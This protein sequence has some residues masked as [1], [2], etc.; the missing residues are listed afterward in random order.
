MPRGD[1]SLVA[2]PFAWTRAGANVLFVESPA[3]VG[4]SYSNTSADMRV[5]DAHTAKDMRTFLVRFL[6][7]YPALASADMYIS[8]E[9][10][11]GHYV[12][13][14]A[15]AIL[16]GNAGLTPGEPGYV[17]LKGIAIGNAWTDPGFDNAG[18]AFHWWSHSHISTAA[19]NRILH[20]CNFSSAGPV[21]EA[22]GFRAREMITARMV[23]PSSTSSSS[24]AGDACEAACNAAFDEMG[25]V[26]IYQ[27]FSDL[28]PQQA[29]TQVTTLLKQLAAS[30]GPALGGM[31]RSLARAHILQAAARRD[32]AA[33]VGVHTPGDSSGD[34]SGFPYEDVCIDAHV[35]VYLNRADV[36]AALQVKPWVGPW[37]MCTDR[38]QY[39]DD[40]VVASMLPLHRRLMAHAPQ[41]L[42]VL[43]YSGD[44]DGI[45]PT[46]GSRAWIESLDLPEA[47]H[48]RPWNCTGGGHVGTQ[49]GGYVTVYDTPALR[50]GLTFATVRG[51]GHMVPGT[52]GARALHLISR[53]LANQPVTGKAYY[54]DSIMP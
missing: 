39:S 6:E 47:A 49:V 1:G 25:P 32:A 38:I 28:C 29:D 26:D 35:A 40:D 5:G 13:T 24:D 33:G 17:N 21:L 8:G 18:A 19:Y 23:M 9:S 42:R 54:A 12:P 22:G 52:Q 11:A 31:P 10:Y 37:E 4:F 27:L 30:T 36:R 43:I 15:A 48:W 3:G 51:A 45:V 7:R 46:A 41:P 53:W 16:D 44:I 50:G 14:I 2:N 20:A 34:G